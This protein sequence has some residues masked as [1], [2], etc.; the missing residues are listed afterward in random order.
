MSNI[1]VAKAQLQ[2]EYMWKAGSRGSLLKR[3]YGT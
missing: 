3:H 1:I 2:R